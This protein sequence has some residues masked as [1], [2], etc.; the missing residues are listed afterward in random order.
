MV[1][2][3]WLLAC[4][5]LMNPGSEKGE[6]E[7]SPSEVALLRA[8]F[9][10]LRLHIQA[11][12]EHLEI[13]DPR[14]VRYILMRQEDCESDLKML[15]RRYREFLDTPSVHDGMRFPDRAVVSELL[16][17][18]RAYRQHLENAKGLV[19]HEAEWYRAA[20]Q[21]TDALYQ[22]WDTVRDA[23]CEYYYITVRRAALKKIRDL[24]GEEA[25]YS[26]SLPPHVP[27]WRFQEIR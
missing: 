16:S 18:N 3:E 14:E 4:A 13:L 8:S 12:A 7:L 10:V 1:P 5:L 23:R 17:F 2:Y 9:P 22:V 6:V 25:Y 20:I 27:I 19:L 26:G 24:V 15:R 21:E 11:L